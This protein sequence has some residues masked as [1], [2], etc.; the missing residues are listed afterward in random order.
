MLV[1]A[2]CALP[3]L[4]V[5]SS[6]AHP[7]PEVWQH[8]R[9][10]VLPG[11]LL[12]TTLLVLG[13]LAGVLLLGVALG[14]LVSQYTFPG[15][16]LFSWGLMLPLAMPAY[17][18]AF[19][20]VGLLDYTGPLQGA[21]RELFGL[22]LKLPEI[23]SLGGA[24]LV[25]SLSFYPY[26]YLL[27]RNAFGQLGG[28]ALEVGASLGLTPAQS[29]WRVALPLARPWIAAGALLAL[30]ETLA[31]FGAVY[32]LGVDTFTTAI[33]KAWFAMFSLPAASQLASL[34]ILLSLGLMML[35]QW[36]RGARRYSPVGRPPARRRLSGARAWLATA[37][38]GAVLLLAFLLPFAQLLWWVWQSG[39]ADLD[40][41]YPAFVLHSLLLAG[42]AALLVVSLAL[43]AA[44]C[45][46]RLQRHLLARLAL[47]VAAVGYAIPGAVLAVGVFVPVAWLDNWLIAQFGLAPG[48]AV[49]KGSVAALL[50]ALACRFL[51]V[52]LSPVGSAFHHISPSQVQAARLLGARGLGLL[53]RLYLP[54]LRSGLVTG[55]LLVFI[56]VMKEMPITL[57]MRP[58]GWDTL[59]VRVFEMTSEGEWQRAALPAVMLVLAG[60]LP[61]VLLVRGGDRHGA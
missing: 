45:E 2:L 58:F 13:V 48:S 3:L 38:C 56:D 50:L 34:L 8:L 20:Q 61:V 4:V 44:F 43:A 12:N 27:A 25:L 53:R 26:V 54:L 55:A 59:A 15:R 1:A 19:V 14:W 17:V 10:H 47:Q 52:A 11:L 7:A 5:V 36:Q 6:L 22:R 51:S 42:L 16:A 49:L 37:L 33:Y 32:V 23:R 46:Y 29:M 60:L 31:D 28:R 39:L 41:R 35:E 57:M 9:Q 30:M 24:V 40:E 18:L 21:L